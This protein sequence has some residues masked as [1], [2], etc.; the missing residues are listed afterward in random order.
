MNSVEEV[1][2]KEIGSIKQILANSLRNIYVIIR[3]CYRK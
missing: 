3:H 2:S 1:K